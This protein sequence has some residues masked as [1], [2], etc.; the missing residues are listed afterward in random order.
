MRIWFN[1]GEVPEHR[2]TL[3][4]LGVERVAFNMAPIVQQ[5]NGN[6]GDREGLDPF[7]TV[8]Y[9]S[10][11]DVDPEAMQEVVRN[12]SDSESL[13]LDQASDELPMIP[14]WDGQ[15]LEDLYEDAV[16]YSQVAI[17][18]ASALEVPNQRALT[19][20]IRKNTHVRIWCVTSKT[21]ILAMP[22]ITDAIVTGWLHA[23]KYRELQMWDGQKVLRV[24][25]DSR[26][27]AI[28]KHRVQIGNLGEDPQLLIEGDMDSN[29]ALSVKSW[30]QYEKVVTNLSPIDPV[31]TLLT[32]DPSL[33]IHD[34][35]PVHRESVLLPILAEPDGNSYEDEDGN[36]RPRLAIRSD[37][38]RKCDMCAVSQVCPMYQKGAR[39]AFKIPISVT[40]KGE[41]E[42]VDELL[43]DM[44]LQRVLEERTFEQLRGEGVSKQ[45]SAELD[46]YVRMREG[47]QRART[48]RSEAT[49]TVQANQPGALSALFGAS[50]GNANRELA[51]GTEIEDAD[52]VGP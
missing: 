10:Q 5:R 32:A 48:V 23:Q 43:L 20:F 37:S 30:K 27:K 4:K 44:Q 7:E 8:F 3:A 41:R 45:A 51:P 25:R 28:E 31:E 34:E 22:F 6:A 17:S 16:T 42:A 18:E 9:T 15:D 26:L 38:L 35:E 12:Y 19:L 50:V 1:G 46:R 2:E 33:A 39:C 11:M 21:K 49:L 40:N 52:V 14:M 24:P 13:V 29:V 47:V 36:L